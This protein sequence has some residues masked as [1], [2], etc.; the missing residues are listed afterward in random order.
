[1]AK[2]AKNK[3]G[4]YFTPEP[5]A[6][7]MA[8]LTGKGK[9]AKVLE[10]SCGEGVFLNVLAHKGFTDVTAFEIDRS[11]LGIH[12]QKVQF[13]SFVT[14]EFNSG[15]DLI[16]GNP[17]YIRWKNLEADLKEEL[18]RNTLWNKYFN[19]LADYLYIFILKSIELLNEDGE[20]IFICPEYWMNTTHS[21]TLRN[22]MVKNGYFEQIYHFNETPVFDKITVSV[23][24]FKYVKSVK[25][26]APNIQVAKYYSVKKITE[27]L[28][29]ALQ[30]RKPY[31]G[32]EYF[33]IAQFKPNE[34]WVLAP[35]E[36]KNVL[37]AIETGCAVPRKN[38]F[39]ASPYST[40]GDIC[41]IG[42]GLVS[43]L[44]KAFQLNGHA[45]NRYETE[46]TIKVV[47]AKHLH[48]FF[49]GNVTKY[50]F[51]ENNLN[52]RVFNEKYPAFAEHLEEYKTAL[53]ER[54]SYGR[55]LKHW[56][57]AFLRNLNLFQKP[58][59]RILVPCKERISNKNHFRFA[60]AEADI[61]PTQDVTAVF[62]KEGVKESIYYVL[63]LLNNRRTFTWLC[64]NGIV[65]GNIVEFSEKPISS[66]PVK[67]INWSD[68]NEVQLHN[69]ITELCRL[70]VQTHNP[71]L[72]EKLDSLISE[73][74]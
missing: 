38:L 9:S 22:Y 34:R 17:P 54:Y 18:L 5:V 20:P 11:L 35:D 32:I 61:I 64:Y 43:G 14:E 52:E 62:M 37:I 2:I 70:Y 16:I 67:L 56:E 41:D 33:E 47:K 72:T 42:N 21:L 65:K 74:F 4:Q 8:G 50:M 7:F 71:E 10:P 39:D 24:V 13:R 69:Q 26:R 29:E 36:V 44:D 57:W 19:S 1:M 53:Y 49:H 51:V 28:I 40:I 45:L 25:Q 73:L 3:Y 23:L 68:A 46:A 63:A 55:D 15:F 48:P 58:V 12:T 66:I 6:A 60:L 27:P 31:E 30:A 59:K